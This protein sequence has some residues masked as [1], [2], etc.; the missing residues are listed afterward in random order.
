[1]PQVEIISASSNEIFDRHRRMIHIVIAELNFS[2]GQWPI[3]EVVLVVLITTLLCFHVPYT[4][5]SGSRLIALLFA[6][7]RNM[8]GTFSPLCDGNFDPV[9][10]AGTISELS[11]ISFTNYLSQNIGD[12]LQKLSLSYFWPP[13]FVIVFRK[14][15]LVHW[16]CGLCGSWPWLSRLNASL[17]CLL[18]ESKLHPD[19]SYPRWRLVRDTER[20]TWT[21]VLGMK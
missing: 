16:C 3:V 15:P 18:S 19:S 12:F 8:N 5:M 14:A 11:E 4:R 2:Q 9:R 10:H 6:E 17:P 7:C 21:Q 13:Q 20:L 1:M